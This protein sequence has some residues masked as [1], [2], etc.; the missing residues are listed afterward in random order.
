MRAGG[1]LMA[2]FFWLRKAASVGVVQKFGRNLV[3]GDVKLPRDN[4]PYLALG[5]EAG[6]VLG[7]GWEGKGRVGYSTR[8]GAA[9]GSLAGASLGA[10]VSAQWFSVDYAFAPFGDLGSV[11]IFSLSLRGGGRP[12]E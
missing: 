11:H 8:S 2:P 4:A 3:A 10:G 1:G 7:G 6:L 5:A 9:A 12:A